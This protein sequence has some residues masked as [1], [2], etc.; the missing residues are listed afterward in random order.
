MKKIKTYGV[1]I[2]FILSIILHFIYNIMPNTFISIIAPVNESIW[3]HMKLIVSSSL[4]F[5]VIEYIIYKT[6]NIPFNNFSLSYSISTLLGVIIYLFIYIPLNDIL[7]HKIYIAIILLFLIF[8]LIQII[9]YYIMNKKK[10]K[11]SLILSILLIVI[12]YF[13]FYYL[14]YYPPKI[15]LFYDYLNKQY[16]IRKFS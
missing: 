7:G 3:E 6:N 11:Y 12:T 10:I 14:T 8:I 16:G 9:S 1:M 4:I 5:S 15:N 2:S 13:I